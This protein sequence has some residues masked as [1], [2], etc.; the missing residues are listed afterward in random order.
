MEEMTD[1]GGINWHWIMFIGLVALLLLSVG[2][3]YYEFYVNPATN[4]KPAAPRF[5]PAPTQRPAEPSANPAPSP[6]PPT[7]IKKRF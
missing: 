6:K 1:E 7:P 4:H 3:W 5:S 2:F